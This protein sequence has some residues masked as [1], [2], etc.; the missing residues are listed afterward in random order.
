MTKDVKVY[1]SSVLPWNF[2]T[3]DIKVYRLENVLCQSQQ[4]AVDIKVYT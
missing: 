2:L 4:T 1:K 3:V